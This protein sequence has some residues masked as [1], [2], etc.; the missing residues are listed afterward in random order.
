MVQSLDWW[1]ELS[2]THLN[3]E[4]KLIGQGTGMQCELS[5]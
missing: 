3:A 2:L 4:A 1:G 5:Q